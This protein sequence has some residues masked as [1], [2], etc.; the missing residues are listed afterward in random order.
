VTTCGDM[1][2]GARIG[3]EG[4]R[5]EPVGANSGARQNLDLDWM[6]LR[7]SLGHRAQRSLCTRPGNPSASETTSVDRIHRF[8]RHASSDRQAFACS[9][10]V[11]V[12]IPLTSGSLSGTWHRVGSLPRSAI[13]RPLA[14]ADACNSVV[15]ASV[16]ARG[17][18]RG[19]PVKR[20]VRQRDPSRRCRRARR[21]RGCPR[22]S[23]HRL[24]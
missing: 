21:R 15:P 4:S 16:T 11:V 6:V 20:Q 23:L 5:A 9:E 17:G 1:W 3:A 18:W 8:P 2:N 7:D 10:L 14:R 12:I 13:L 19:W 24:R 22:A